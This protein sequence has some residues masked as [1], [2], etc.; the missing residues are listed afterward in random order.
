MRTK[1]LY[2]QILV[3]CIILVACNPETKTS[4]SSLYKQA[5][6]EYA[7]GR[8]ADAMSILDTLISVAIEDQDWDLV[9]EAHFRYNVCAERIRNFEHSS[10]VTNRIKDALMQHPEIDSTH[11][12]DWSKER[13]LYLSEA[14]S[15]DEAVDVLLQ[16]EPLVLSSY[17]YKDIGSYY[18]YL[19]M[20]YIKQQDYQ[21]AIVAGN[22]GIEYTLNSKDAKNSDIPWMYLNTSEA[23]LMLGLIYESTEYS[24]LAYEWLLKSARSQVSKNSLEPSF[25]IAI[26]DNYRMAKQY[27]EA[28][29]LYKKVLNR[30]NIEDNTMAQY[31]SYDGLIATMNAMGRADSVI[32][33]GDV[34]L[35]KLQSKS[36]D[37]VFRRKQS[38][39]IKLQ[40]VNAYRQIGVVDKIDSLLS[41][42][43]SSAISHAASEQTDFLYKTTILLWD[44]DRSKSYAQLYYKLDSYSKYALLRSTPL[45]YA[46]DILENL[47]TH[48]DMASDSA[49]IF[50]PIVERFYAESRDSVLLHSYLQNRLNELYHYHQPQKVTAANLKSNSDSAYHDENDVEALYWSAVA[51]AQALSPED[52]LAKYLTYYAQLKEYI[53]NNATLGNNQLSILSRQKKYLKNIATFTAEQYLKTYDTKYLEHTMEITE[54]YKNL[55]FKLKLRSYVLNRIA[56]YDRSLFDREQSL[57]AQLRIYSEVLRTTTKDSFTTPYLERYA[58]MRDSLVSE[59]DALKNQI[60]TQYPWYYEYKYLITQEVSSKIIQNQIPKKTLAL[61]FIDQNDSVYLIAMTKDAINLYKLSTQNKDLNPEALVSNFFNSGNFKTKEIEHILIAPDGGTSELSFDTLRAHGDMLIRK[62]D[63]YYAYSLTQNLLWSVYDS[64]AHDDIQLTSIAP[65]FS[66]ELKNKIRVKNTGVPSSWFRLLQQPFTLDLL[67]QDLRT[68]SKSKF[69][70]HRATYHNLIKSSTGGILHIGT[71]SITDESSPMRDKL[72][73]VPDHLN[74]QG[75]LMAHRLY[76][77]ALNYQMAVL[78]SCESA[79]GHRSLESLRGLADAF[80]VAGCQNIIGTLWPVDE[81]STCLLLKYFYKNLNKKMSSSQAL[82]KA[83]L[84]LIDNHNEYRDPLYWAGVILIGQPTAYELHDGPY[85]PYWVYILLAVFIVLFLGLYGVYKNKNRM[86]STL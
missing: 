45:L 4:E 64:T 83:K 47:W 80:Y 11:W 84:E 55:N 42:Y 10:T 48:I 54:F 35:S 21:K 70:G 72:A 58:H 13:A 59:F 34:A 74:T 56:G 73:L 14:D 57:S 71:H 5:K 85:L 23:Y 69:L 27:P 15:V 67:S 65:G 81:Q 86:S 49:G 43:H 50:I 12:V 17:S 16:M 19:N 9:A 37:S 76:E 77:Q 26:A 41:S 52:V 51:I 28:K 46:Q 25:L 18:D 31:Y 1:N 38:Q 40:L 36:V 7:A 78:S 82:R 79:S 61:N 44:I 63:L 2:L 66:D 24:R 6:E 3:S 39:K 22:R 20:M 53:A 62:Y 68:Y 33:Y 8:Y 60:V 32:H 29:E 30:S 75:Y